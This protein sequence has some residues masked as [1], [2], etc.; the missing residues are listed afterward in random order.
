MIPKLKEMSFSFGIALA[1]AM[2][3]YAMVTGKW[4]SCLDIY[5]ILSDKTRT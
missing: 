5:H 1:S 4:L 3:G 2:V